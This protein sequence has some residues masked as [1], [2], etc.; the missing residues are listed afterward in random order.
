MSNHPYANPP[1]G[2]LHR[3]EGEITG[4]YVKRITNCKASFVWDFH[5]NVVWGKVHS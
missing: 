5:L 2:A 3:D 4:F 1:N